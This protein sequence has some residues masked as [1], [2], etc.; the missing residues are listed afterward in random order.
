MNVITLS[1][2]RF[3][4]DSALQLRSAGVIDDAQTLKIARGY[5]DQFKDGEKVIP[6]EDL[7]IS[8]LLDAESAARLRMEQWA[9]DNNEALQRIEAKRQELLK[10]IGKLSSLPDGVHLPKL[11][12]IVPA[13]SSSKAGGKKKE[14]K[15]EAGRLYKPGE[16]ASGSGYGIRMRTDGKWEA[17]A[18]KN[19]GQSVSKI[20]GEFATHTKAG[21]HILELVGHTSNVGI[22]DHFN[23]PLAE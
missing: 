8:D 14:R 15:I 7:T 4:M 5:A 6:A 18:L 2:L 22:P 20:L 9:Q 12:K 16:N 13:L 23:F 19:D 11:P 3:K 1:T 10:L 21:W 17:V